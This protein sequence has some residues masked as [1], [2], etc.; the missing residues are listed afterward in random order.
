MWNLARRICIGAIPAFALLGTSVRWVAQKQQPVSSSELSS[1]KPSENT[2][3]VPSG[4]LVRLLVTDSVNGKAARPGDPIQLRV[5]DEVRVGDLVVIE[6]KAPAL[7]SIANLKHAG[8]RSRPG[9]MSIKLDQVTLVTGQ[10]QKLRG[11][12]TSNGNPIDYRDAADANDPLSASLVV[13]SLPFIPLFHGAEAVLNKGTV[14]TATLGEEVC[15]DR[16]SVIAH[17]PT[18]PAGRE[19]PASLTVYWPAQRSPGGA[20]IFCGTVKLADLS[21]GR[22]FTLDLPGGHYWFRTPDKTGAISLS[23]EDGKEYFVRVIPYD[24][25]MREPSHLERVEHDVGEA[26]AS[27]TRL[28]KVDKVLNVATASLKDLQADPRTKK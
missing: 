14:L 16:A 6:N 5:I 12:S 28:L 19:G 24:P 9:T 1:K 13:L 17:Q 23:L 4:T 25:S 21:Q 18:P 20:R 11:A 2:I 7:A 8:R 26:E 3:H 10:K 22:R 15:L 27:E